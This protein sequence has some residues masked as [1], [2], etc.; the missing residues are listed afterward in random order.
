LEATTL[1]GLVVMTT[2]DIPEEGIILQVGVD[3]PLD[4][5]LLVVEE[6]TGTTVQG[7]QLIAIPTTDI[8][9]RPTDILQVTDILRVTDILLVAID[10]LQG[11]IY[12]LRVT[13][14][15]P[16]DRSTTIQ[17]QELATPLVLPV[18]ADTLGDTLQVTVIDTR[19]ILRLRAEATPADTLEDATRHLGAADTETAT[20]TDTAISTE[21]M[22][23][24]TITTAPSME[25]AADTEEVE[26]ADTERVE[27]ADTE[28][29]EAADTERVEATATEAATTDTEVEATDT[30]AETDT[31]GEIDTASVETDTAAAGTDTVAAETNT[32]A[33]TDTTTATAIDTEATLAAT[34]ETKETAAA[35]GSSDRTADLDVRSTGNPSTNRDPLSTVAPTVRGPTAGPSP[36]AQTDPFTTTSEESDPTDRT[37]RGATTTTSSTKSAIVNVSVASSSRSS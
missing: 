29:V 36:P 20:E 32:E 22:V 3:A 34:T 14:D 33:V 16:T 5:I 24:P 23:R 2:T 31:V 1:N 15:T 21:D 10:I 26:A 9:L 7:D 37:V 18:A 25:E 12:I 6:A 28:R 4:D 11:E 30:A 13:T 17:I 35:D 27:A 8:D 19:P